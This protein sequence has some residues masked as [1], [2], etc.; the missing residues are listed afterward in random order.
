[1]VAKKKKTTKRKA[2]RK[3]TINMTPEY[4]PYG[5]GKEP[6]MGDLTKMAMDG[7][8]LSGSIGLMGMMGG[9]M[10]NK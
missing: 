3:N 5:A 9:M 4:Q 2:L 10:Q 1:M 6:T 8:V 7:A